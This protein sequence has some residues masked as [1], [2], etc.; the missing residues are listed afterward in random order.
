MQKNKASIVN[1]NDNNSNNNET[2]IENEY[3]WKHKMLYDR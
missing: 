2:S 3:L 1:N